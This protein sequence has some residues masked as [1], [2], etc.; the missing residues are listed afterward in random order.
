MRTASRV[1]GF[2]DEV[3]V[4]VLARYRR[5]PEF[6]LERAWRAAEYQFSSYLA[7]PAVVLVLL[8]LFAF[9]PARRPPDE[10]AKFTAVVVTVCIVL[11][12]QW[13]LARRFRRHLRS[14]PQ[15]PPFEPQRDSHRVR[16]FRLVCVTV[17]AAGFGAYLASGVGLL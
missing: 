16:L 3:F 7:I 5:R 8:P 10:T 6:S 15:L 17:G 9:W 1:L 11:A 14:P 2:L 4:A 13:A 12:I